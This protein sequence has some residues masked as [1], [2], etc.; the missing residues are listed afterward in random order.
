M[1]SAGTWKNPPNEET[2]MNRFHSDALVFGGATGD[3]AHKKIFPALQ[4][5]ARRGH[6]SVP[7]T[8]VAKAGWNSARAALRNFPFTPNRNRSAFYCPATKGKRE[9][10]PF[11]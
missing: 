1:D 4:A 7:I 11:P 10:F 2:G 9:R 8:G 6:L 3:L 5:M